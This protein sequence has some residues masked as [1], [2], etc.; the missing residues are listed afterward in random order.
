MTTEQW[1]QAFGIAVENT[2]PAIAGYTDPDPPSTWNEV[3][4]RYDPAERLNELGER[5]RTLDNYGLSKASI[6]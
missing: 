6:A 2:P 1:A 4:R 5:I 3:L